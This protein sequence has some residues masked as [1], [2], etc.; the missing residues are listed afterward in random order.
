MPR[1][2]AISLP[3]LAKAIG[4]WRAGGAAQQFFDDDEGRTW[5]AAFEK[6]RPQ[7]TPTSA[8]RSLRRLTSSSPRSSRSG[9][10]CLSWPLC[11][12]PRHCRSCSGS[13]HSRTLAAQPG[14]GRPTASSAS[15]SPTRRGCVRSFARSTISA[16]RYSP[17]ARW[18]GTFRVSSPDD[19]VQQLVDPAMHWSSVARGARSPCCSP[20]SPISP[21]RPRRPTR[22]T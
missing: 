18:C 16:A 2:A 7:A 11:S 15:S 10:G 13:A 5:L 19:L 20:M 21:P 1:I 6:S 14:D 22:P 9:G 17:C 3:G 8:S 12:W 4:N